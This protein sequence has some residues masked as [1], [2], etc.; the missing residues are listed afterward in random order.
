MK[1]PQT[2]SDQW[3]IGIADPFLLKFKGKYFLYCTSQSVGVK[4]WSSWDLLN[5]NYDGLC[6]TD[7]V[8]KGAYAPEVIY[9]NGTFYMY[10]SPLGV[11][12][13]ILSS[14]SPTGPFVPKTGNLGHS[15]D[16]SVFVE[17][18]GSLSFTHA[19][20]TGIIRNT[21]STPLAID[22]P[23]KAT[24]ANLNG[25]TEASTIFKRNGL[26]YLLY[27]GNHF[28]SAGYRVAYSTGTTLE[29]TFTPSAQNPIIINTEDG[30]YGLGH[31]CNIIGPDLDTWYVGYHNILPNKARQLNIDP[32]G[33]N[34]N[35]LVVYGPTNWVQKAPEL[36]TFYDRFNRTT[37]GVNW[38]N[39]NGGNWGLYNQEL[40][41]Q[42][43]VGTNT[44]YR[45]LAKNE[46]EADFTAEFNMKEMA[47]GGNNARF[48][49]VFS[50]VNESN[51]GH[52][53]FSSFDNT[54]EVDYV[55][56]GVTL[57]IQKIP[58]LTL[59]DSKKWHVIRVEKQKDTYKIFVDGMLKSTRQLTGLGAGKI[60][61]CTFNDHADFGY[62]AFSNAVNGTAVF[63]LYKPIPGIIEA[64]HYNSGGEG[65][66]FHDNTN[67][68]IG[69]AYRN[70]AVDIRNSPEGGHVIAWNA[71]G[72]WYNYH[73]NVKAAGAYH[74]GLRYSTTFPSCQV[75]VLCDG[76]DV[77]GVVHLPATGDFETFKTEIINTID[78]PGG[79]HT[80]T[81]QTVNGEFDF[82]T[83]NFERAVSAVSTIDNFNTGFSNKWNYTDGS[84]TSTNGTATLTGWGK[85][86]LGDIGWSDYY[87]ESDI[88]LSSNGNVGLLFRAQNPANG[89]AN[90]NPQLGADFIQAYFAEIS[91]NGVQLGKLNYNWKQLSFT[92]KTLKVGQWYKLRAS[93]LGANIKIYVDDMTSPVIDY[94]DPSPL[95]SGKA[96]LRVFNSSAIVDNF[97]VGSNTI[98]TGISDDEIS[99]SSAGFVPHPLVNYST[100]QFD[101]NQNEEAV[102]TIYTITG[103]FVLSKKTKQNSF[104]I[105][106]NELSGS[107]ILV[108]KIQVGSQLIMGK[109]DVR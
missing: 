81:I 101:N 37:I 58:L 82:Y 2:L 87:V 10:I 6:A 15:I 90:D 34:G 17:D 84:W 50:Y 38:T 49:A 3:G 26:Y 72:E 44:W 46:S 40:M 65:I 1:N 75:R 41:W 55:V 20:T 68:N 69:G 16:G 14:N 33:F 7:S 56:N 22:G 45:Q 106:R 85:R 4:V 83:I 63:D 29:G 30:F 61:V 96:G 92:A 102:L 78:L 54:L 76:N 43:K 103:S 77:S 25:W 53:I 98:V 31:T 66:A 109:L 28:L 60:G 91:P 5:W 94:T 48:G 18:D 19:G 23:E 12:H 97:K 67:A 89:G 39:V 21:M 27:T 13:Y 79:Y 100:I 62:T 9:Y 51:F 24:G 59:W 11:G 108:Y 105:F 8:T 32:V 74:I 73:V 107:G 93:V 52:A 64:V 71:T 57:G 36:P 86:T 80:L 47:R 95:L 42:D 70:E 104:D 88:Q 99:P 35:K